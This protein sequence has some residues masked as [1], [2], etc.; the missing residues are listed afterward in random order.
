MTL[1][2]IVSKKIWDKSIFIILFYSFFVIHGETVFNKISWWD[3]I[4]GC[5]AKPAFNESLPQGR[6]LYYIIES[7][8]K[9][10]AGVESLPVFNGIIVSACIGLFSL[11]VFSMFQIKDEKIKLSLGLIFL[12]IPSVAG[13]LGYRLDSGIN[14]IGILICSVAA[15]ISCRAICERRDLKKFLWGSFLFACALGEYQCYFSLY[16]SICLLYF[17]NFLLSNDI[18][19][20]KYCKYIFCY[21]LNI[22]LGLILYLLILH[23]FL[24]FA[25][26]KLFSYANT[27]TYGIVSINEYLERI[28]YAYLIFLNP[29]LLSPAN[30]FPFHWRGWY[31]L[32]IFF[33]ALLTLFLMLTILR[34]EELKLLSNKNLLFQITLLLIIFPSTL[35]FNG[36]LYGWGNVH[37]LHAYQQCL[38]FLFPFIVFKALLKNLIELNISANMRGLYYSLICVLVV[39]GVL[40]IRYDNYCYMLS[41]IR[42]TQAIRYFTTLTTR[43][44]SVDGYKNEMPVAFVHEEKKYNSIDDIKEFSDFPVTN[45]YYLPL[46]DVDKGYVEAIRA[47][48]KYWCGYTP[49]FA[50]SQIYESRDTVKLMPCYPDH[51]SI[52]IID[53]VIVVKFSDND[54]RIK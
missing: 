3:D 7:V 41:E 31:R 39:F 1:M 16:L 9:R 4:V 28:N 12:S 43:I 48:M 23:I 11:I 49:V 35:N 44:M 21:V 54:R 29:Y 25:D 2:Q 47:F 38:L 37:S 46:I 26:V 24:Y 45:P 32:L 13:H 10:V 8:L 27:N 18:S 22:A 40:Y 36:I 20:K 34:R 14:F 51:G 53:N 6:W 30:M 15:F 19:L 33:N 52:K 5:F 42:Q 50:N 17:L